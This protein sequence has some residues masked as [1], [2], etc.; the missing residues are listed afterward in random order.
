MEQGKGFSGDSKV[1]RFA[2]MPV[3]KNANGS[4]SRDVGKGV[5][6]TGEHVGVHETTQAAGLAANPAHVIAHTELICVREGVLEF[7]HDGKTERAEVGDVIFVAKGTM[8]SVRN[9]GSGAASY[10]VVAVGGDV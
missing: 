6:A 5:L 8:H 10:F 3:R 2:E 4:Q 7:V 9:V 1:V